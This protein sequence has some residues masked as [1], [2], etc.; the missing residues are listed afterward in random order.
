MQ[1]IGIGLVYFTRISFISC[2][3]IEHTPL[4]ILHPLNQTSIFHSCILN[5]TKPIL[6]FLYHI[7]S[8]A[9]AG[10]T[11]IHSNADVQ[12]SSTQEAEDQS[13]LPERDADDHAVA[14]E[15]VQPSRRSEAHQAPTHG[16]VHRVHPLA[17]RDACGRGDAV[18]GQL[19]DCVCWF[20]L[21]YFTRLVFISCIHMAHTPSQ[22][23]SP[24]PTNFQISF[25]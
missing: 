15:P 19:I 9:P 24:S 7:A 13:R 21:V 12:H 22:H 5:Q 11:I 6:L 2:I 16:Q 17:R 10:Q 23:T 1:S 20:G 3:H 4:N 14:D 25:L 8:L 18:Y